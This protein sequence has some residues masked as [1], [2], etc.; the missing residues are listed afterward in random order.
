MAPINRE[1]LQNWL[2]QHD[3]NVANKSF[4]RRKDS[5]S[6][7]ILESMKNEAMLVTSQDPVVQRS[8]FVDS[9]RDSNVLL[10]LPTL[11]ERKLVEK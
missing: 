11:V 5:S 2:V 3:V 4:C 7:Y 1:K 8:Y 9:E 10:I 6:N